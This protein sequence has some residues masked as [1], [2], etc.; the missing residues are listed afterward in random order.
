ML[1]RLNNAV[2]FGSRQD[3]LAR[4]GGNLISSYGTKCFVILCPTVRCNFLQCNL[5]VKPG[6]IGTQCD[7][8]KAAAQ[9]T[10]AA[11]K[12]ISLTL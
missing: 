7:G 11:N 10:A 4:L 2:F 3:T 6:L 9:T 12:L 5:E 8:Q 1:S